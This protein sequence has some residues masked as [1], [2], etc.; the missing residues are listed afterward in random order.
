MKKHHTKNDIKPMSLMSLLLSFLSLFVISGILFLKP[1]PDILKTLIDLDRLICS[2]FLLLWTIDLIRSNDKKEYLKTHW[3][4]LLASLPIY[5]PLRYGRLFQILRVV[6]VIRSGKH[7]F[8]Q[9]QKNRREATLASIIFLLV[10]LLTLGSGLMIIVEG[11]EPGANIKSGEDALWWAFVT[12][13]TVGY[14][15]HYPVTES[16]K[17]LAAIIIVCGVGIFGMISGLITSI[18][19]SPAQNT[20]KK[21][22]HDNNEL[23]HKL[24]K[25]QEEL[26]VKV[27]ELEKQIKK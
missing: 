16:G 5:E 2:I 6:R 10:M 25:Q 9:M 14:G 27:E 17:A 20:P 7:I 15:D 1:T 24:L 19:S 18:I 13:S 21:L 12:V 22:Q 11:N 3:I 8:Q 26:L 23:L 4:D